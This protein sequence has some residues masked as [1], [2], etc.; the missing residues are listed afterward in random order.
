V[1][2]LNRAD[3]GWIEINDGN[4]RISRLEVTETGANT[5]IFTGKYA[6]PKMKKGSDLKVSYGYLGFGKSVSLPIK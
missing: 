4:G 1:R 3:K 5:G 6:V 2:R